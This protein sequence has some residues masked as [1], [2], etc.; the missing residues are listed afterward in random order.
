[1]Q[2]IQKPGSLFL[3]GKE[4]RLAFNFRAIAEAEAAYGVPLITGLP[5][6]H[7]ATPYVLLV[8]CML[9]GALCGSRQQLPWEKLKKLLTVHNLP[10][11]WA[12]I[13]EAWA[14]ALPDC[15]EEQWKSAAG[16]PL[17]APELWDNLWS[18]ARIDL[19]LSEGEFWRMTPR[20]LDLLS[21]RHRAH[22]EWAELLNARLMAVV[23]NYSFCAPKEPV[24]AADFMPGLKASLRAE[25]SEEM[26]A[27]RIDAVFAAV[28]VPATPN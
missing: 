20:Q 17:K 18:H 9:H 21:K 2:S 7:I 23:V 10:E 27:A 15:E 24:S 5:Q 25:I 28:A 8:L 6:E 1:M 4:Y 14:A 3:Q 22:R 19:G 26:E 11:V 12:K 16:A 13:R